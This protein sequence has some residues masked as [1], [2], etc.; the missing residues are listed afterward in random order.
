MAK[1]PDLSDYN[2]VAERIKEFHDKYPEGTLQAECNFTEQDGRTWVVVKAYAFRTPDDPRPGTG[3]AFELIPGKTPYTRDS[4]LQNAETAAWG[5]AIVAVGASSTRK[6]ASREE[7]RN[8][9]A[10]PVQ[11]EGTVEF[12]KLSQ[13]RGLPLPMLA[14]AFEAKFGKH[15]REAVDDDLKAFV[16]LVKSG[17]IT[18]DNVAVTG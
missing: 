5:R 13:E 6:I 4:E 10:A 3:L 9:I 17:T 18:F 15:P 1:Q 2:E 14:E 16:T 8:R 12:L 7:V 11:S